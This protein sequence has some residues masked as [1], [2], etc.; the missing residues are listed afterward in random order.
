L[1][2]WLKGTH[3][4]MPFTVPMVWREPEDCLKDSYFCIT[5]ITGFSQ[6]S[7]QK[8][9]YPNIPFVLRPVCH[10]DS[11]PLPKLRKSS[12]LGSDSESEENKKWPLCSE[13]TPGQKH[14]AHLALVNK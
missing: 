14:V 1:A 8:I 2:G 12:T 6:F 10:D 5:K 13:T 4:P 3:K 7:K 11:M 9:K